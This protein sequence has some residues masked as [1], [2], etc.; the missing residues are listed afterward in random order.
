VFGEKERK[1][2]LNLAYTIREFI[3]HTTTYR[4]RRKKQT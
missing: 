1:I 4:R 2:R 3:L